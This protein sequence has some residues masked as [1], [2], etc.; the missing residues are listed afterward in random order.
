MTPAQIRNC[1][2]LM[3]GY[4]SWAREMIANHEKARREY[5]KKAVVV[6]VKERDEN[7]IKRYTRDYMREYMREYRRNRRQKGRVAV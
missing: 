3:D 4:E 5:G 1:L 7:A 2:A 6:P